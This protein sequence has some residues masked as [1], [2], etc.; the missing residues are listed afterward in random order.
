[1][2]DRHAL[3]VDTSTEPPIP[4]IAA[5]FLVVFDHR[6]GSGYTRT[7]AAIASC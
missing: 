3:R 7:V 6:K 4:P 2:A 5:I 1:M